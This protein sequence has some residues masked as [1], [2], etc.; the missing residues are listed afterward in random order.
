MTP[1]GSFNGGGTTN[2]GVGAAAA[3]AAAAAAAAAV[4]A[5]AAAVAGD[6]RV[7]DGLPIARVAGFD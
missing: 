6:G 2:W 7:D 4:A 3:N 1:S 5:A